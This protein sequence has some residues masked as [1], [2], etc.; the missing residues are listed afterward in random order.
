MEKFKNL[1]T[2]KNFLRIFPLFF[3]LSFILILTQ[4]P[5][6]FLE[7]VFYDLKIKFD[8]GVSPDNQVVVITLDEESDQFLGETFPY[9]FAN[10]SKMISN[11]QDDSPKV[12]NYFIS[13]LEPETDNEMKNL[14]KFKLTI[15][16]FI[17]NKGVFRFA[18]YEDDYGEYLP[19]AELEEYGHSIARMKDPDNV[20]FND[21]VIR[22]VPLTHRGEPSI[23]LWTANRFRVFKGQKPL[24][25]K[26][27]QGN[28]YVAEDDTLY[29]LFRYSNS[30]LSGATSVNNIPFHRVLTGDFPRGFFKDKIVLIGPT[31]ISGRE[32][33][34]ATPFDRKSFDTKRMN[35]YG[36]QIMA[37]VNGKTVL[38]IPAWATHLL[39]IIMAFILSFA[40]LRLSPTQGLL[41]V[42]GIIGGTFLVSY[43]LFCFFGYWLQSIHLIISV[44]VVYYIWIPFRAI[45]EYKQRFAY[46]EEAK[47]LKKVEKLK[48]N[49]ISL[50]SH[51]LKTPVAK[52]TVLAE[53]MLNQRID[54]VTYKK[55]LSAIVAA[56]GELNNFISSI[57]DLAKIESS[58]IEL[59]KSSMDINQIIENC[60]DK[61]KYEATSAGVF[62]DC[63]LAPLYP[64]HIDP[65]LIK[66]VV[67]NLV[68]N[69]IKYSGNNSKVEIKTWDDR[70]F[71]YVEISDNGIGIAKQD[72]DHVFD[73]FYRVKNDA[74]HRIKGSGLG[75]YLVKFFVEA[76]GGS[77]SVKS[78]LG[79]GTTFLLKF[80]NV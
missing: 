58:K 63:S 41:L 20:F 19:P 10:H 50:M 16:K 70:D 67:H 60:V 44:F 79:K 18:T 15:N 53:N 52:I 45:G 32:N 42:V 39:S 21:K 36:Q 23:F 55:N 69:A 30:P 76:H 71:V 2:G 29:S 8:L 78:E 40:I 38:K 72:L 64:I 68:E 47:L 62:I 46:E 28:Y 35:V 26:S 6:T 11:L 61:L 37:L 13:F 33:Y 48:Q 7:S 24:E 49:F 66:R 14:E 80:K 1:Y 5:F 51:D 9:T 34:V 22:S 56:T 77:I 3:T 59:S 75:L 25:I 57:L 31:Y 27:L 4:Y 54:E 74:S 43:L 73:K 17:E 12:I 65:I